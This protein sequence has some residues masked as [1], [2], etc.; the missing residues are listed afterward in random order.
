MTSVK[1]SYDMNRAG[2]RAYL[3]SPTVSR[4]AQDVA[5]DAKT[6]AESIAPVGTP[7]DDKHPGEYASRFRVFP[8]SVVV[9]GEPRVSAKLANTSGHA[10][11]VEWGYSGSSSSPTSSAHRVL[12]RTLEHMKGA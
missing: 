3:L 12:G 4:V 2:V 7:P 11:A 9:D 1:V 10:A 8:S 6:Y 5:K